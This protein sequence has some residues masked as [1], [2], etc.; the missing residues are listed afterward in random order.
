MSEA[1]HPSPSLK[2]YVKGD[3][4]KLEVTCLDISC[5]SMFSLAELDSDCTAGEVAWL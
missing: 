2:K 3:S 4:L 5:F 1:V